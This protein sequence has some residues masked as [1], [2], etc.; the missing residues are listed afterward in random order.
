LRSFVTSSISASRIRSFS[1]CERKTSCNKLQSNIR[2]E[3]YRDIW[4]YI[5]INRYYLYLVCIRGL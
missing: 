2:R 5:R 3:K 1:V 4:R